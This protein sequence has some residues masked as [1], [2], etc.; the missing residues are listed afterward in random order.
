MFVPVVVIMAMRFK[1]REHS[2]TLLSLLRFEFNSFFIFIIIE[3]F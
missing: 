3:F 1:S 2:G